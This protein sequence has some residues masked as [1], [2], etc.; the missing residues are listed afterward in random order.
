MRPDPQAPTC[1]AGLLL[2]A[3]ASVTVALLVTAMQ[4]VS[5]VREQVHVGAAAPALDLSGPGGLTFSGSSAHQDSLCGPGAPPFGPQ[6]HQRC[7]TRQLKR[8]G[9]G[10]PR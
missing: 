8:S 9:P 7:R 4:T 6:P 2:V 1:L 10:R 3:A 5:V